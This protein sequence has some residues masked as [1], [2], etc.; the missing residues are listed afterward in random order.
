M[1]W[2]VFGSL[3]IDRTYHVPHL[4]RPGETVQAS[5]MQLFAGGKGLNQ[6]IAFARAGIQVQFAGAVGE[7]G[8]MLLDALEFGVS[9]LPN[10]AERHRDTG[11][12]ERL[13]R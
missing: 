10:R 12:C 6:A 8:Q 2:L 13:Y 9:F 5:D 7:D 1:K 3:N 11:R 4:V